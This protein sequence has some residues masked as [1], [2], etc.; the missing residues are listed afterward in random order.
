MK[1]IYALRVK[2]TK[3]F[4]VLD[5][6]SN[7][8]QEFCGDVSYSL[9]ESDEPTP[10]VSF[11]LKHISYVMQIS[12][13]WYNSTLKEPYHNKNENDLE[14][15]DLIENKIVEPI[16]VPTLCEFNEVFP[17]VYFVHEQNKHH[18]INSYSY[19]EKYV[20]VIKN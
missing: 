13:P 11:D 4:L 7:K 6:Y 14:I 19:F 15:V 2:K 20:N 17:D 16:K 3:K 10:Y 5:V 9:I 18:K 8:S 12:T 1:H